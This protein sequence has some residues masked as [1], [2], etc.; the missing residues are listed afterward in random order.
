MR[1]VDFSQILVESAQLCGLDRDNLTTGDFA[2]LRDFASQRL[3]IIWEGEYWPELIRIAPVLTNSIISS[4]S[5]SGGLTF[6]VTNHAEPCATGETICVAGATGTGEDTVVNAEHVVTS[7]SGSAPTWTIV[8]ST[9]STVGTYTA[10]QTEAWLRRNTDPFIVDLENPITSDL[11]DEPI[12]DVLDVFSADPRIEDKAI[13]ILGDLNHRAGI[14]VANVKQGGKVWVKYRIQSPRLFGDAFDASVDYY[15]GSQVWYDTGG[16]D[17]L[18]TPSPGK[19]FRGN[20]Y[21][22]IEATSA[23]QT[24]LSSPTKW[25]V[26]KVPSNFSR[27]LTRA[28]QSDYLR[29]EQQYEQAAAVEADAE[30][31]RVLE[32]DKILRQQGQIGSLNMQHTY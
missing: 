9:A 2:M 5:N 27:Y 19:P 29:S 7:V 13:S 11:D 28:I 3:S 10:A 26:V 1:Q 12:G 32:V 23:G 16:D 6:T 25:G 20:F 14:L 15:A 21:N 31:L 8:V 24:P 30:A 4:V 18:Y 22:C 17:A